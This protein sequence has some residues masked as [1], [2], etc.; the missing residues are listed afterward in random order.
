[1]LRSFNARLIAAFVFVTV[2]AVG[3]VGIGAL[4]LLRDEQQDT[5]RERV[6]RH[7][8]P[9]AVQVALMERAGI[10]IAQIQQTLKQYAERYNIRVIVLDQDLE[11]VWDS[12]HQLEGRYILSFE[13]PESLGLDTPENANFRY[14]RLEKEHLLL[15]TSDGVSDLAKQI[16][17]GASLR[18][19][20]A[21]PETRIASAWLDLA[22]RLTLAAGIALGM[23]V[24]LSL[25][26]S[27]SITQPLR[28]LTRLAQEIGRGR[29]D[30]RIEPGGPEEVRRLAG[31][32]NKMA[33]QVMRSD[34]S[35][36]DLLANVSHEL[37]TPLTSIQGFSQ[38][39]VDGQMHTPEDYAQAARII[40]EE[41][42]RMRELVD[43]LL[44]LSQMQAGVVKLNREPLDLASLLEA[45]L[46]RFRRRAEE[47]Q[48]ALRLEIAPLPTVEA[49]GRRLE[50]VFA[51][52][53]DNAIH[54]SAPGSTVTVRARA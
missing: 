19:L 29:Y 22:P 27:R 12:A 53:V 23:A 5:A 15:F 30:Q 37:K 40:H 18:P 6:G 36:R 2:W 3:S 48:T 54:H 24:V 1:M 52:L 51:N 8:E 21:V 39:M 20:V 46:E 35:M 16:I 47:R 49:D 45:S 41:A 17:A 11:V 33:G 4:L 38:A 50:Q 14:A 7:A 32:F 43:D 34:R 9:L 25:I 44:Y 31:A 28:K 26:L 13:G 42:A 10:G